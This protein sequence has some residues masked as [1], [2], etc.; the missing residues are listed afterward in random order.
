MVLNSGGS[1][2]D[3]KEVVKDTVLNEVELD[4]RKIYVIKAKGP[5]GNVGK[6]GE[7]VRR[8]LEERGGKIKLVI[9]IDAALKLEGERIG[10]I[11]EGVGAA[12]GGIGVD[13]YKIEE[14]TTKFKV[15]LLAIVIKES[16]LNAVAA[17]RKEIYS[18]VDEVVSRIRRAILDRTKEGDEIIVVGVG[19][20]IGVM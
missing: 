3:W 6:P 13:K 8:L 7:A 1:L 14:V 4:K 18:S 9:M 20:S 10:S 2:G 15:P 12:I 11:A 19:N 5:G 17:M 16:L